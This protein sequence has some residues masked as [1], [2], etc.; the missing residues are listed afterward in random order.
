[1]I[2]R[3]DV[4]SVLKK[5]KRI[6]KGFL[7]RYSNPIGKTEVEYSKLD[8]I[9]WKNGVKRLTIVFEDGPCLWKDGEY[10]KCDR[11]RVRK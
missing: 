2:E 5:D 10:I 6:P 7:V 11:R 3:K 8:Q 9:S 4:E 1:M